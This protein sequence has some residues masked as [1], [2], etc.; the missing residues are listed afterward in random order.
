MREW[1]I[2]ALVA[3]ACWL[4][5]V[6]VAVGGSLALV[7]RHREETRERIEEARRSAAAGVRQ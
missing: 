1:V 3:L 7:S 5:T 4:A 6:L 2:V